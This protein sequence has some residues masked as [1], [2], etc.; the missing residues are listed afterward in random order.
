MWAKTEG[1]AWFPVVWVTGISRMAHLQ[2]ENYPNK[3]FFYIEDDDIYASASH[4]GSVL[5][6]GKQMFL[7][8]ETSDLF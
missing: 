4:L 2:G 1:V 7:Q 5:A 3:F 6:R 8:G